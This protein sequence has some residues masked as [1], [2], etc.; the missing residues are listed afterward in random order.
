MASRLRM[1]ALESSI[2]SRIRLNEGAGQEWGAMPLKRRRVIVERR[3]QGG[4]EGAQVV[5]GAAQG[6]RSL[7]SE[8]VV[9]ADYVPGVRRAQE[10][11]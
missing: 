4:E 2:L 9:Q 1:V 3:A 7:F 5:L 8:K 10:L 6:S 11:R